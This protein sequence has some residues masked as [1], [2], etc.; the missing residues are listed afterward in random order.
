M[1]LSEASQ[2][3]LEQTGRA[4]R[5]RRL[6][7]GQTPEALAAEAGIPAVEVKALEEGRADRVD[8]LTL[9]RLAGALGA[10]V[11]ELMGP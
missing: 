8:A 1:P 6:A 2:Q 10:T 4:I 5:L 3:R 9:W 11:K 7:R